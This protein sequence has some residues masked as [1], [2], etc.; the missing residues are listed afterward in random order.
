MARKSPFPANVL[1]MPLPGQ[2]IT[3]FWRHEIKLATVHVTDNDVRF[4]LW[5]PQNAYT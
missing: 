5:R 3:S 2:M 4:I 1:Q